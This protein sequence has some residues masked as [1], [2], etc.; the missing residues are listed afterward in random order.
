MKYGPFDGTIRFPKAISENLNVKQGQIYAID[1]DG[2]E[3]TL[4]LIGGIEHL[5]KHNKKGRETN[6]LRDKDMD[7]TGAFESDIK[8]Y[9]TNDN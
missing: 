7:Y 5:G 8:D 4:H 3:V 6:L 2:P 1:M 9:T